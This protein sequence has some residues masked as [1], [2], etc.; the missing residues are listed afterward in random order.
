MEI[1]DNAVLIKTNYSA[2]KKKKKHSGWLTHNPL[3][4][5]TP[6]ARCCCMLFNWEEY[7]CYWANST[8]H[9]NIK[10]ISWEIN[11]FDE[12]EK[13]PFQFFF[14]LKWNASEFHFFCFCTTTTKKNLLLAFKHFCCSSKRWRMP[15]IIIFDHF[16]TF[17]RKILLSLTIYATELKKETNIQNAL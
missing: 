9:H 12:K 14:C 5:I 3:E 10:H 16:Y 2:R 17:E 7:M 13:T 1:C 11:S 8:I 6:F 4:S 15:I